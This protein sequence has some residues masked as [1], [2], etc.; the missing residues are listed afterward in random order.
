[1]GEQSNA[2]RLAAQQQA[3]AEAQKRLEEQRQA[4]AQKQSAAL[5]QPAAP[6]LDL[7]GT[8]QPNAAQPNLPQVSQNQSPISQWFTKKTAEGVT[9]AARLQSRFNGFFEPLMRPFTGDPAQ[10]ALYDKRGEIRDWFDSDEG[11]AAVNAHPEDWTL[12]TDDPDGISKFYT[13]YAN[14]RAAALAVAEDQAVTDWKPVPHTTI[15]PGSGQMHDLYS[16]VMGAESG[17]SPNAVSAKGA[18]GLM[19]IMPKTGKKPG[20]GVTP[21][22]NTTPEEN[23]RFG[24]DYLDAM[25][26][27]YSGD[28]NA[29]LVAYNWGPKKADAWMKYGADPAALPEETFKYVN[30]IAKQMGQPALAITNPPTVIGGIT[31]GSVETTIKDNTGATRKIAPRPG[32]KEGATTAAE[33]VAT[34]PLNKI[35]APGPMPFA[36]RQQEMRGLQQQRL[37]LRDQIAANIYD[38]GKALELR[39]QYHANEV[40]I[41]NLATQNAID[42]FEISDDPL[43]LSQILSTQQGRDI[44]IGRASEDTWYMRV[45]GKLLDQRWTRKQIVSEQRRRSSKLIHDG[46][47]QAAAAGKA[48]TDMEILKGHLKMASDEVIGRYKLMGERL[49]KMGIIKG[50]EQMFKETPRG[51]FVLEIEEGKDGVER[52]V[53]KPIS[54]GGGNEAYLLDVQ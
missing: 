33:Q 30:K 46:L 36:V 26:N 50:L 10:R 1:L 34:K 35:K 53:W 28:L 14:K 13:K 9:G 51:T 42:R 27:R 25:M 22:R 12:M 3:Q 5:P 41:T 19:Q 16:I 37:M 44:Q 8:Q 39:G 15:A 18:N 54:Q 48:K 24:S 6:G 2:Q 45:D 23:F 52:P 47:K 17:G 11:L 49:K 38:T 31:P 32:L 4:E 7:A 40:L 29:A 21:L 43:M 20:F